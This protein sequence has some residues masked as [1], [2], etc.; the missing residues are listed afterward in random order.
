M[1]K[2]TVPRTST[3]HAKYKRSKGYTGTMCSLDLLSLV[4]EPDVTWKYTITVKFYVHA[5][6]TLVSRYCVKHIRGII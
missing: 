6:D 1:E 4:S 2:K 3:V 5:Y